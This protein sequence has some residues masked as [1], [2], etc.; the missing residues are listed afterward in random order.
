[1]DRKTFLTQLGGAGL[2]AAFPVTSVMA[3]EDP[4]PEIGKTFEEK[5][6]KSDEGKVLQILGN[7]QIHKLIGK[8]TNNQMV[9]W[10]DYLE[11]GSGIPPHIH[12]KEDE[13]FRVTEGQVELVVAHKTTI[14]NPG[15]TALA[16]KNIVHYWKVIG[17]KKAQMCVSAFPAGMEH[18]FEELN[19]LPPGKPDFKKISEIS[20]KYGIRFV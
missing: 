9:E 11:P 2:I 7:K 15:D 20:A 4:N 10:I 5:V 3:G 19:A 17:D 8:D 14:L 1:M 6:V 12:T 18:M 13:I 16:P